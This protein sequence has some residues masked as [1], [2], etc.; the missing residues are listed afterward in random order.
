[1]TTDKA[2]SSAEP[3]AKRFYADA[4][5]EALGGNYTVALDGRSLMTPEGRPLALPSKPLAQSIAAEWRGQGDAIDPRSMPMCGLANAAIDRMARDRPAILAQLLKFADTEL[6]CYRAD[7]PDDLCREQDDCW[8]PLLDWAMETFDAR[9]LATT[10]VLPIEQPARSLRALSE[11]LEQLDDY[12]LAAV[13]SLAAAS[14]SLIIAL[15]LASGR[16]NSQEAARAALLDELHQN[17]RWGVD[18]EAEARRK[19]IETDI[20]MARNFLDLLG[21]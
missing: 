3:S 15:A 20:E 11:A 6:L 19:E 1:M 16:I 5:V 12:E 7:A 2:S 21:R 8:Q 9:L 18:R 10:G 17:A 13:A 14:G 4:T